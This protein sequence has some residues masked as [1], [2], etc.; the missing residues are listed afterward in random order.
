MGT[1]PVRSL[2]SIGHHRAETLQIHVHTDCDALCGRS[3][4][5]SR[6]SVHRKELM[7]LLGVSMSLLG[8]SGNFD[9]LI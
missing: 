9:H 4:H 5:D 8:V 1:D 6:I 2:A 3:I 7:S